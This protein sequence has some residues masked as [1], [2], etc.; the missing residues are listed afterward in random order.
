MSFG[1]SQAVSTNF[2]SVR[3]AD[4]KD[5]GPHEPG[6][7]PKTPLR[8]DIYGPFSIGARDTGETYVCTDHYF[9]DEDDY[10]AT[11]HASVSA[12]V[13]GYYCKLQR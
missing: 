6:D 7:I 10:R 9:E 4:I 13:H 8:G 11:R 5:P 3:R 12:D 2:R 1:G